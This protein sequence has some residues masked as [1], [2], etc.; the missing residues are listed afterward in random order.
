MR[1]VQKASG[2]RRIQG[3]VRV[4]NTASLRVL[5]KNGCQ[6]EGIRRCYPFG[7]EFHDA[8]MLAIVR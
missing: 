2:L 5:E 7:R 6:R 3:L 1:R 4:E 8:A